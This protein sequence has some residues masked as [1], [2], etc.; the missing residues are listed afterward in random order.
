MR[1]QGSP[2][3]TGSSW[4]ESTDLV[5]A[6]SH[7]QPLPPGKNRSRTAKILF[8]LVAAVVGSGMLLD[9]DD[10]DAGWLSGPD[11]YHGDGAWVWKPARE[12]SEP[13][14]GGEL[15]LALFGD[16]DSFN[17][18]VSTVGAEERNV[19]DLIFPRLAYEEPNAHQGP[20][21]LRPNIAESWKPSAD[22]KTVQLT[23][24]ESR[25]SDGTPISAEDVRFSWEAARSKLINWR[26]R[27]LVTN[28]EDVEIHGPRE[29]EVHFATGSPYNLLDISDI[30]IVPEHIL[31]KIPFETWSTRAGK[32]IELAKVGGGPFRLEA[33]KH[34][35]LVTLVRNPD[36]WDDGKPYIER[37]HFRAF[38]STDPMIEALISGELDVLRK[39]PFDKAA[40]VK[41]NPATCVLTYQSRSYGFV[42]WNN[43]RPP[44]DDPRVRT[45]M[46]HAIHRTNIVAAE[47]S[48]RSKVAAAAVP[49]CFWA[50]NK[51]IRPLPFDQDTARRLLAEAGFAPG[52]T[53]VLE[54]DGEPLAFELLSN[55][56]HR[57]RADIC[58]DIRRRLEE[59]GVTVTV[60]LVP[61][62]DL[63]VKVIR[64]HSFDAALLGMNA[65][66][67]VDLWPFFHSRS[68]GDGA[69]FAQYESPEVDALLERVRHVFDP[70]EAKKL[71]D[72]IQVIIHRDQPVTMLYEERGIAACNK[73]LQNVRATIV[74]VYDNLPTWWF[75]D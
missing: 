18:Y 31:S 66:T 16:M 12:G 59:I 30:Y 20:P 17:P 26:H 35:E 72:E 33:Y 25:W 69:N 11:E 39:V 58:E 9:S 44:F 38:A 70:A 24:R 74:S 67:K 68:I 34:N 46:T 13:R 14:R 52:S 47:F 64:E 45:A 21:T 32:W 23:L 51:D 73:R 49:S 3:H 10:P 7:S 15:R 43:R 41:T 1:P 62:R 65:P 54:R 40:R 57:T 27:S 55:Q 5:D 50:S 63:S 48:Q 29:C 42:A 53:G 36:F 71:W 28:V 61:R 75:S 56:G 19:L 37:V 60:T 4:S 6:M 8:A 2:S 22:G